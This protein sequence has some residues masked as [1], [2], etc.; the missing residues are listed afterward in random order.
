MVVEVELVIG[1]FVVELDMVVDVVEEVDV[2]VDVA[3]VEVGFGVENTTVEGV[4]DGVGGLVGAV[5]EVEVVVGLLVVE[6]EMVVVE[7]VDGKVD[8]VEV[9]VGLNVVLELPLTVVPHCLSNRMY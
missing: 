8:V 5:V 7:E 9:E 2:K 4:D 3:E 1:L 6:L